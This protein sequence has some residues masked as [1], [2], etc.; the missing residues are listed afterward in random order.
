M[1]TVFGTILPLISVPIRSEEDLGPLLRMNPLRRFAFGLDSIGDDALLTEFTHFL[2][3][4]EKFLTWKEDM[5]PDSDES[6]ISDEEVRLAAS[7]FSDYIYSALR[8]SNISPEL[9][10]YLLI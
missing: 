4:Y 10:K 7:Q 1:L 6:G 5:G 8:N 9:R 2:D 3:N